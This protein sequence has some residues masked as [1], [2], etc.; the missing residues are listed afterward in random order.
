VGGDALSWL[1]GSGVRLETALITAQY[2]GSAPAGLGV[3]AESSGV[4]LPS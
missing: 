4:W 2:S 3:D 1:R